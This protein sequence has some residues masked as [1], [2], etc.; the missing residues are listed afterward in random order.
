MCLPTVGQQSEEDK[1]TSLTVTS[2][3]ALDARAFWMTL[4]QRA[5]GMTGSLRQTATMGS[6][7]SSG[8]PPLT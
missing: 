8:F 1:M 2:G 3:E 5:T 7:V 6:P 4:G